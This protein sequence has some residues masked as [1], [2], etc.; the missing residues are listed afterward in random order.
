MKSDTLGSG[1]P[2]RLLAFSLFV[3]ALSLLAYFALAFG[4]SGYLNGQIS[5]KETAIAA[6]T[7]KVTPEAQSIFVD[8]YSRLFNFNKLMSGHV[9]IS[10]ALPFLESVTYP[11]V[12]YNNF[13]LDTSSRSIVLSGS[14]SSFDSLSRQLYLY[15][16]NPMI[17]SYVLNQSRLT[18]GFVNFGATLNLSD[19]LFSK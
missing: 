10:K 11:Y 15:D 16:Q 19:K 13:S 5:S 4:Y 17:A 12:Y 3:F 7:K 14:A 9:Y 1:L 6:L 8:F 18:E 2:W